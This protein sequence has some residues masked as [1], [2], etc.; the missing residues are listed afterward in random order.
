MILNTLKGYKAVPT[1]YE[2]VIDPATR[3]PSLILEYAENN[4]VP[5]AKLATKMKPSDVKFYIKQLLIV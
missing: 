2:S 1:F 3:V 5:F 4:G